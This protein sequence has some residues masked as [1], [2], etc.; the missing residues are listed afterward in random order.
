MSNQSNTH[1]S[2]SPYNNYMYHLVCRLR[3]ASPQGSTH[4]GADAAGAA[5]RAAGVKAPSMRVRRWGRICADADVRA[6][7]IGVGVASGGEEQESKIRAP[8]CEAGARA[9]ETRADGTKADGT[10]ADGTSAEGASH[11]SNDNSAVTASQRQRNE[12]LRLCSAGESEAGAGGLINR[13]CDFWQACAVEHGHVVLKGQTRTPSALLQHLV[14]CHI[15]TISAVPRVLDPAS[16]SGAI[17]ASV[18]VRYAEAVAA[19]SVTRAEARSAAEMLVRH[20][21]AIDVDP[22][23]CFCTRVSILVALEP[24]LDL[25]TPR[26]SEEDKWRL[27]PLRVYCGN[28]LDLFV[29]AG[30]SVMGTERGKLDEDKVGHAQQH[31]RSPTPPTSIGNLGELWQSTFDLVVQN[32]P[33]RN[34]ERDGVENGGR[35][36]AFLLNNPNW[37]ADGFTHH[38]LAGYFMALALDRLEPGGLLLSFALRNVCNLFKYPVDA[39]FHERLL[40][41]HHVEAVTFF[42]DDAFNHLPRAGR[43]EELR[44]ILVRVRAGA[45]AEGA[46]CS[47]FRCTGGSVMD[48]R[49]EARTWSITELRSLGLGVVD[50]RLVKAQGGVDAVARLWRSLS[51]RGGHGWI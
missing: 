20:T 24:L 6:L 44:T 23:S 26:D 34:Q 15:S 14:S 12:V 5:G 4:Q 29:G 10:R 28:A 39:R 31:H 47:V 41:R 42:R 38:N 21:A 43:H 36:F 37:S 1:K 7:G 27:P 51:Q 18:L 49:E 13:I 30:T 22:F 46:A 2:K 11:G 32:P 33:F 17:L 8:L 9:D 3:A 19:T 50:A 35:N 40:T 48:Q 25:V 16:G 45:A